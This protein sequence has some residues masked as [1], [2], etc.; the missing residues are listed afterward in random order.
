M[1]MT[2]NWCFT[3]VLI[4][5][6]GFNW[7]FIISSFNLAT[8]QQFFKNRQNRRYYHFYMFLLNLRYCLQYTTCYNSLLFSHCE[9]ILIFSHCEK[10]RLWRYHF[11]LK[12]KTLYFTAE[13]IIKLVLCLYIYHTLISNDC[14]F[15]NFSFY[16]VHIPYIT[17]MVNV[18]FYVNV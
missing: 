3:R 1:H 7:C 17:V 2:L 9:N 15:V 13:N 10:N 12:D 5:A 8:L 14:F 16:H 4:D 11:Y 18:V 6:I